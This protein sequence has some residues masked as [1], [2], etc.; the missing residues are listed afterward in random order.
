[1]PMQDTQRNFVKVAGLLPV[2]AAVFAGS[3]H[4]TVTNEG[5]AY[6]LDDGKAAY[7]EIHMVFESG[8]KPARLVLYR[9]VDGTA[10]ARKIVV[11]REG[12]LDP[13]FD[14][15]D[16]RTGY[17]EGVRTTDNGREVYWQASK[18]DAEKRKIVD[19]P[20]NAVIDAGFDALVRTQWQQLSSTNGIDARFLLP[21]AMRFL[22]VRIQRIGGM[23]ATGTT[24][25]RM[26]LDSWC[27]FAAPDT[28]LD[29]QTA[30]R[31]LL[32]FKG[33]GNIRDRRGRTQAVRIEFPGG[34]Q[35]HMTRAAEI[36]AARRMPLTGHC[37]D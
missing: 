16:G 7:R 34:L 17:R 29:Y 20:A 30:D 2:A 33:I 5:T 10:F 24:H 12:A 32:R 27:G 22:K 19:A 1:M 8:G 9:C 25:L 15:I 26:K 4:A 23:P 28:N 13:D 35:P 21:S 18:G 3:A 6:R 11:K 31:H 14:F 37:G 36:D